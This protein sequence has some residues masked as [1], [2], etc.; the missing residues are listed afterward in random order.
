M[1]TINLVASLAFLLLILLLLSTTTARPTKTNPTTLRPSTRIPLI[2]LDSSSNSSSEARLRR[3]AARM[4]ALVNQLSKEEFSS[5]RG[6]VA[7]NISV[8][9]PAMVQTLV[10]DTGS[11]L[12][13]LQCKSCDE[14]MDQPNLPFDPAASSSYHTVPCAT[15]SSDNP[16]ACDQLSVSMRGCDTTNDVCTYF[17]FYGDSS[18]SKGTLALE[19]VKI[20]SDMVVQ[21]VSVGCGLSNSLTAAAEVDGVLGLGDAVG[22]LVGQSGRVFSCCLGGTSGGWIDFDRSADTF[23]IRDDGDGGAILDTGT[24]ITMLPEG[25]YVAL[26]DLFRRNM[27][28]ATPSSYNYL[29]TCYQQNEL[30]TIP[31]VSL[32]ISDQSDTSITSENPMFM[33]QV[34]DMGGVLGCLAFTV[35]PLNLTIIGNIQ[36]QG[37]QITIDASS[38]NI[39]I[40]PDC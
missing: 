37:T 26:R 8:G 5:I 10:A 23:Q 16:N 32:Y 34:D 17:Y 31:T 22:S 14:C 12:L 3:D 11:D 25:A 33:V 21:N 18:Y 9:T 29:D 36:Q 24:T 2:D 4:A 15:S 39:G 30:G 28:N 40:G 7:V 19:N 13:W 1:S 35:S 6:A 27:G 20:N 38:N